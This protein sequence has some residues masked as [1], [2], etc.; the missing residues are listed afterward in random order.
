MGKKGV[1]AASFI[2][3]AD[4]PTT[5]FL[6]RK[7]NTN[8]TIQQRIQRMRNRA[9]RK[10]IIKSLKANAHTM[11]QVAEYIMSELGYS[12]ID[13]S[14]SQY[15][16]EYCQMRA[17]FLLQYQP[18]LL[19]GLSEAPQL[20]S[21]DEKSVKIFFEQLEKR[22]KAAED[23]PTDLFDIDL[24]IYKKKEKNLESSI[25]IEKKYEYIGGSASGSNRS[26]KKYKALFRKIYLYYGVTQK[27]IDE[28]T[29]RYDDVV[30]TL[31]F[32]G[33]VI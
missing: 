9:R 2:G 17:S 29:K 11:D 10:Q 23:I 31:A 5:V 1:G 3:G 8:I 28:H 16:E 12:E 14:D 30:K 33:A 32:Y 18:S 4:G 7:D 15:R 22:Q 6:E 21:Y 24:H 20:K 27:D 13:K 25:I 26:M 19:G